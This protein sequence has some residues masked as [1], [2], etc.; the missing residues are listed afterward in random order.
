MNHKYIFYPYLL[1]TIILTTCSS[2]KNEVM[3]AANQNTKSYTTE[4]NE[5]DSTSNLNAILVDPIVEAGILQ[6]KEAKDNSDKSPITQVHEANDEALQE[7]NTHVIQN[8]LVVYNYLNNYIYSVYTSPQRVTLI[9]LESEEEILGELVTG[10][11]ANWI[12]G[13]ATDKNSSVIYIKPVR[14]NISTNMIINTSRRTY[15]LILNSLVRTYMVSVE[16]RYPMQEIKKTQL[17]KNILESKV[18]LEKLNFAYK[19]IAARKKPE[20]TPVKIFDDGTRTFIQFANKL[21]I[22]EAPALFVVNENGNSE[23]VNYRVIEDYYVIDK[24]LYKAELRLGN[25]NRDAVKIVRLK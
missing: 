3:I 25:K 18:A 9:R 10:D 20:W 14:T 22:A 11:T 15:H 8:S 21:M 1:L 4:Q 2:H 17:R 5:I 24:I 16:W 12:I 13:T 19:I 7:P 23:I 6:K